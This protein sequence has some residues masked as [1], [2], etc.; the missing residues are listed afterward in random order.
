MVGVCR[1]FNTLRS[2]IHVWRI[3]STKCWS[4]STGGAACSQDRCWDYS[5]WSKCIHL[6]LNHFNASFKIKALWTLCDDSTELSRWN[7][8]F[9]P[10]QCLSGMLVLLTVLVKRG[11]YYFMIYNSV[12][13][14]NIK[15]EKL[16]MSC[17][18]MNWGETQL[19]TSSASNFFIFNLKTLFTTI[20]KEEALGC[21]SIQSRV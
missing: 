12:L 16:C 3:K 9:K 13:R 7:H 11:L 2:Q 20:A 8:V 18:F 6:S 10:R 5:L 14:K 17:R 19:I 4:Y 21:I 1:A 15:T